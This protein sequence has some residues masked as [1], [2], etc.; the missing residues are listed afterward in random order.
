[1]RRMKRN[2]LLREPIVHGVGS[3]QADRQRRG[4]RHDHDRRGGPDGGLGRA[5][6]PAP[7]ISV[8]PV[9]LKVP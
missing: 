1:M 4:C 9:V 8:I 3:V 6:P 7:T 2:R 5:D